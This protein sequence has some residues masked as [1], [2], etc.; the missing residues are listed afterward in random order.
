MRIVSFKLKLTHYLLHYGT[1]T[2]V[3]SNPENHTVKRFFLV[4]TTVVLPM[5][6]G[7]GQWFGS[8]GGVRMWAAPESAVMF[9]Q[10]LP[11][12]ENEVYSNTTK[13][14][15]LEAAVNEVVSFQL[16]FRGN[17]WYYLHY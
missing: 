2:E 15:R 12:L 14:V 4:Y 7:C 1:L 9:P 17:P 10:T 8:P 5:I 16:A 11:D 6:A 3:F 13:T